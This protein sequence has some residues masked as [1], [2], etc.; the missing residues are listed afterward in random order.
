MRA[1]ARRGP[2]GRTPA[3][4]AAPRRRGSTSTGSDLPVRSPSS[5]AARTSSGSGSLSGAEASSIA[6]SRSTRA[7][8]VT[9]PAARWTSSA[10]VL[11][12]RRPAGR[13]PRRSAT[14]WPDPRGRRAGGPVG[15]RDGQPLG[16]GRAAIP[17]PARP[18]CRT[19]S[20]SRRP[21][22]GR[23]ARGTRAR[24]RA[25]QPSSSS[26]AAAGPPGRVRDARPRAPAGGEPRSSPLAVVAAVARAATRSSPVSRGRSEQQG[27]DLGGAWRRRRSAPSRRARASRGWTPT[28]PFA[29]ACGR[30]GPSRPPR[31]PPARSRGRR[32]C[33]AGGGGSSRASPAAS[34]SPQQAVWRAKAVRSASS[35]SGRGRSA[36][37][38]CSDCR[39]AAVDAPRGLASGPSRP[40][41]RGRVRGPYGRQ[42]AEATGVVHARLPRQ[43]GVHHGAHARDRQARLR[44]GRGQHDPAA[45]S[46]GPQHRVL[47]VGRGP[48]VHLQ[49]LQ[50]G[51]RAGHPREFA[52]A[53]QEAQHVAV[54]LIQRPPYGAGDVVEQGG[55]DAHAV[56]RAYGT[57]RRGPH[58]LDRMRRRPRPSRPGHR[59]E[60]RPRPGV[61][62]G[63]RGDEAQVRA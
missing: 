17:S 63:R 28:P 62:G 47:Y 48:A 7:R 14:A 18:R 42:R 37:R 46:P 12:A 43:A 22:P 1:R 3:G 10:H 20:D 5:R 45:R 49:H 52:R 33:A 6:P 24:R 29:T 8:H 32:A 55:I 31:R 11:G 16:A 25:R 36:S 23:P 27:D 40:L 15:D 61:G 13:S 19:P 54:P 30:A 4:P 21:A 59:Q 35:I 26:S 9:A 51:Q 34:G 56:R 44:H 38:S 58:H 2:G 39:P 50:A 41:T 57:G 60:P 53:G